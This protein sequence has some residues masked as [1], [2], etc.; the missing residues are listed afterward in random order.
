MLETYH[1]FS[2]QRI[3]DMLISADKVFHCLCSAGIVIVLFNLVKIFMYLFVVKMTY[4]IC[5]A[6]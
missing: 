1:R 2:V 3:R 5:Y 4:N 6:D